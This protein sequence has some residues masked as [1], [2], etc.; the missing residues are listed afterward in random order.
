MNNKELRDSIADYFIDEHFT[1]AQREQIANF[2]YDTFET[3]NR[4][5]NS[6]DDLTDEEFEQVIDFVDSNF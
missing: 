1:G 5:I 2:I 4:T 3:A 6:I